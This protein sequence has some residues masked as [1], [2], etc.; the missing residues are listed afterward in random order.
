LSSQAR[1]PSSSASSTSRPMRSWHTR[2]TARMFSGSSH[3]SERTPPVLPRARI[4]WQSTDS[5]LLKKV[6]PSNSA[7]FG[8]ASHHGRS[9]RIFF[10]GGIPSSRYFLA[11]LADLFLSGCFERASG[12]FD[13]GGERLS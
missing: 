9:A 3:S 11:V 12:V 8:Q 2:H 6:R 1:R 4:S 13:F 7:H 5:R 10:A